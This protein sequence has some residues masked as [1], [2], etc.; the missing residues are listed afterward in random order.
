LPTS[1]S[2]SSAKGWDIGKG[3]LG[4]QIQSCR[5]STTKGNN[6]IPRRSSGENPILMV[7]QKPEIMN[8]T[9]DSLK[10]TFANEDVWTQ[11]DKLWDPL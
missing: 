7:S 1:K 5:I 4:L 6:R 11:R 9:N 8:Q 10:R 2:T 3:W